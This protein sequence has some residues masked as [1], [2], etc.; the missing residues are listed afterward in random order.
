[1]GYSV[2]RCG[3]PSVT[4]RPLIRNSNTSNVFRK[5][6]DQVHSATAFQ[7]VTCQAVPTQN[8]SAALLCFPKS[9]RLRLIAITTPAGLYSLQNST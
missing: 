3:H 6:P 8:I 4:K 1:M 5:K 9:P 7:M 2:E